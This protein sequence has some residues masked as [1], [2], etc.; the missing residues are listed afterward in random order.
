MLKS[1]VDSLNQGVG[2]QR[3]GAGG[4]VPH[5][6][7]VPD[8]YSEAETLLLECLRRVSAQS[9]GE[10]LDEAELANVFDQHAPDYTRRNTRTQFSG[11]QEERAGLD[12]SATSSKVRAPVAFSGRIGRV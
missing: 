9:I 5:G 2:R 3:P 10:K 12:A 6:C 8:R 1:E 11:R 7:V 4:L